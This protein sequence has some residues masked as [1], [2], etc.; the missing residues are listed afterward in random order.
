MAV[1][2]TSKAAFAEL[3]PNATKVIAADFL[4]RVLAAIPY[5]VHTILTDNGTQFGNM[6]HQRRAFQHVFDRVCDEHAIETKPAHPWTNGQVERMNRTIKEATVLRY[7]YQT[8]DQLNGHLQAFLLAYN[9]ARRLKALRGLT[10][11]QFICAQHQT[12][13]TTFNQNPTHLMLGLYR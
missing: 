9:H 7:H 13:P 2:R 12:N 10:P 1:D 5:K 3:Q 4:R 11:H 8:T 6:P